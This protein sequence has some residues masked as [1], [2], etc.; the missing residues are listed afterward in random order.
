MALEKVKD[1]MLPLDDYAIVGED[2]TMLDALLALDEAQ[3]KLPPG[4]QPHRA[5]LVIDKNK[6]I[7][8]KLGH[9]A[10][11]KGLEPKY[12]KIGDVGVLARA[13]L[14]PDFIS[15]MVDK[16]HLW[17]GDF[18]DYVQRAKQTKVKEVMHPAIESIDEEEP[19]SDA[20]HKLVMYQ[21]LSVLVTRGNTVVGILRLS[22][23]F[24]AI[25]N[26]IKKR[27]L[28]EPGGSAIERK[29]PGKS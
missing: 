15:S 10:F 8:G 19:L 20:I 12:N 24:S 27:A 5:V 21:T 25:T 14:T 13:G 16:W 7:V 22:D 11:L 6:K 2:A 18:T 28:S 9:L 23:L 3:K 1:V 29:E 4:R 26:A 17:S